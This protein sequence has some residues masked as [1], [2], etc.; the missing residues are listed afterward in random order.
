MI[1]ACGIIVVNPED[2]RYQHLLGK[3]VKLPIETVDRGQYVEIAAHPSVKMEFGSG[4][5][6]VCS[7]GDQNDVS[8]FRE[9]GM[10]PFVAINLNGEMTEIS[11]PLSGMKVIEARRS[12]IEILRSSGN[13]DSTEDRLQ[14]VPVS[15]RGGNPIEIIL[16]KEWYVRQ[17]HI[18]DRLI[19]L[20]DEC[21]FIPE[22]NRQYLH[23]WIDGISIDW[24]ISRRRWYHT[25]VPI[26]YSEDRTKVVVPP[27]GSY[28][29][30]WKDSPPD[31]SEVVIGIAR[32]HW[33]CIRN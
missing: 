16:L 18:L 10:R 26:W 11:G 30:P 2:D 14:E 17:T 29:Q 8:I 28:V 25:E 19:E 24:P 3:R 33:D 21:K 32:S 7:F 5:L 12:A 4:I 31:N 15:E 20:S 6:M 22:R 1:C 9:L 13:L 27:R 23:D